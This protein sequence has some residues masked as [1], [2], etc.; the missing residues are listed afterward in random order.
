MQDH[1]LLMIPGPVELEPDI[2]AM[3]QEPLWAHYGDAW[4]R[5]YNDTIA[6]TKRIFQTQHD[7]FLMPGPGTLGVDACLCS[8]MPAHGKALV[9]S[10][11]FFGKRLEEMARTYTPNVQV[12]ESPWGQPLDLEQVQTAISKSKPDL[13]VMVQCE[14]STTML[15]PVEP[16]GTLCQESGALLLVDAISSLGAA[17]LPV[18]EWGVDLCVASTQKALGCPPGLALVSVSA[19]AWDAVEAAPA[20][21]W[22]QSLAVWRRY[23]KDWGH[24]FPH[25]V[26]Q[27]SGLVRALQRSACKLLD[28]GLKGCFQRHL[29]LRDWLRA[30]AEGLGLQPLIPHEHASPSVTAFTLP[31]RRKAPDVV[32]ALRERHGILIGGGLGALAEHVIRI[33]HMGPQARP[34]L[35][36][37]ACDAL[38][39][40]LG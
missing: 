32:K 17:D 24:W 34:P 33:G 36:E 4:V 30:R 1:D 16:V 12:I 37:R 38:E 13:V 11:G 9:L 22:Y 2:L 28:E 5:L 7:L 8:A 40:V 27:N 10:N 25:P 18:D 19:R 35:L 14:T 39:D 23:A 20:R 26:T 21:G 29:Q 31:P 3:L 15:N 6:L